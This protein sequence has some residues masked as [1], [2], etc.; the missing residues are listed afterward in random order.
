[1]TE[2]FLIAKVK[3]VAGNNGFVQIESFSDF[4]ERFGVLSIVFIDFWGDK[5]KFTVE[6]VKIHQNS[7]LLKFKNFDDERSASVFEGK[8][9]FVDKKNVVQLPENYFFVHDLIGCTFF[10]GESRLGL[11]KDVLKLPANDVFV[12]FDNKKKE[13]FVP[14]VLQFIDEIDLEKKIIRYKP[15][16]DFRNYDED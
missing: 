16:P 15:E 4:P 1:M 10:Q 2:Y 12:V 6:Q 8:E 14:F 11:V 7:V 9:I 3:S 13:H 5:K